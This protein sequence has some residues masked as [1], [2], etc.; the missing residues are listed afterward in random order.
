MT[1]TTRRFSVEVDRVLVAVAPGA[2]DDEGAGAARAASGPDGEPDGDLDEDL[3]GE[4]DGPGR[5]SPL[6]RVRTGAAAV[7][8]GEG[9]VRGRAVP[10]GVRRGAE[11]RSGVGEEPAV[12]VPM[13]CGPVGAPRGSPESPVRPMAALMGSMLASSKTSLRST[14]R[15]P[16]QATEI[17]RTVAPHHTAMNPSVCRMS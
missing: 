8:D 16:N 9:S 14:S 6:S 10:R 7:L 17:A 15:T 3:D 2:A 5:E 13:A 1:F 4:E 12:G 11:V